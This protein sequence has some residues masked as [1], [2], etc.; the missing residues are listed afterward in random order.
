MLKETWE[1][2]VRPDGAFNGVPVRACRWGGRWRLRSTPQ[3]LQW[4]V[5]DE[6][7]STC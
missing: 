2:C 1:T 6:V 5:R 7:P 3:R 4:V